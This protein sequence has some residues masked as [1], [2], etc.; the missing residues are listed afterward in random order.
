MRALWQDIRYGARMLLKSPGFTVIVVFVLALGVGANTAIFSVVNNVLLRALPFRH[1]DRTVVVWEHNRLSSNLKNVISAANFLDWRDAQN[2]FDEMAAF[3]DAR[4]NLTG[5]GEPEEISSQ[6]TTANLFRLLGADP[7]MGR[8]FTPEDARQVGETVVVISHG[9]W[10]RRFGG[11]ADILG[12][13]ITLG[14]ERA[15]I[16]GVMPIDFKWFIKE[17]SRTGKP[18]EL[19]T[20]FEFTPAH[21]TE[22]PTGRGRYMTAV[23]RLKPGVSL[24]QAEAEMHAIA[25]RLEAQHPRYN[26]NHGVNLVPVREQFAGQIKTALFVLLGAVGFVLLIACANVANLLLARAAARQREIA[27]RSAL[28]AGRWRVVR[29]LLTESL[30]LSFA[31][32]VL[33]LA[34][35][36]WGR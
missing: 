14:G 3:Y 23:A 28:G 15:T 11:T 18:A 27:I 8:A 7:A 12:K 24:Q 10:Q 33:G 26:T 36:M 22:A 17:G 13:T 2:V 30:L 25:A 34:L 29:Q 32:G 9:L 31:G 4:L 1:A 16:V 19:W 20:P 21:R 35:A 6:V 5:T